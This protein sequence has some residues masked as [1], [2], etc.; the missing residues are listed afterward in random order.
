MEADKKSPTEEVALEVSQEE[1]DEMKSN[2]IYEG[3]TSVKG[4]VPV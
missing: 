2:F 1:I 3:P 4:T